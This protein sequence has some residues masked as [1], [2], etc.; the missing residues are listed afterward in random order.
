MRLHETSGQQ[1]AL[2]TARRETLEKYIK[3]LEALENIARE[4]DGV[5]KVYAI[6]AGREIRVTVKPDKIDDL[7]A[8]RL[9]KGLVDR[10]ESE[11][12]Y[13]GQIRVTIIRETRA[14][15]YAK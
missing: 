1:W 9:A 12:D 8:H 3:R 13:P 15:E 14:V 5:E 10:V 7:A 2:E 4:F 6:Q 11:V